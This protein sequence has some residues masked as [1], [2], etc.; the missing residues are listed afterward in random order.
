[1]RT[2]NWRDADDPVSVVKKGEDVGFCDMRR[3]SGGAEGVVGGVED[4]GC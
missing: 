3:E 4:C 1:M 2:H